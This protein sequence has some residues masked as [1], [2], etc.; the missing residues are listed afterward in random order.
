MAQKKTQ[1]EFFAEIIAVVTEA[2]RPDLAEFCEGRIKVLDDKKANKKPTKTQEANE[3]II[4][5]IKDVLAG[6][7]KGVTIT[8]LQAAD[9]ILG[10]LSNQKVSSLVRKLVEADEVVKTVEKKKSY[11]A[12]KG[13]EE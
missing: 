2:G 1:R 5:L 8:E 13:A 9:E 11:F 12:L 3:E 4:A 6:F 10:G 7:D